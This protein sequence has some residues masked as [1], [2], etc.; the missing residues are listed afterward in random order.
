[1]KK[2]LVTFFILLSFLSCGK[3]SEANNSHSPLIQAQNEDGPK[4]IIRF[5]VNALTFG[6]TRS[7]EE[8]VITAAALIRRIVASAE[9]KQKVL[10]Y[11]FNGKKQ[12]HDNDGLTN[13]QIYQ[14][15][16]EGSEK[17]TGLGKNSTMD[18]EL[19]LYTDHESN[20]IGYTYPNIARV[21][22]NR[23]YFNKFRPY[24]VAD[25][26]MH[27]WLHKIGFDHSVKVNPERRHSVPYAIGY[28]VKAMAKKLQ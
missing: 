15:I 13:K 26:M 17:M 7:Q 19:E 18:L 28:I 10:N 12:F 3:K 24:E 9:F 2:T 11:T 21:F 1:L 5:D 27:E 4:P 14:K 22:M 25:N 16:I 20:T 23:K 8:K 6:F